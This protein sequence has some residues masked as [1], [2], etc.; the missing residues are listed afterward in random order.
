MSSAFLYLSNLCTSWLVL[1]SAL[2]I[3]GLMGTLK[4]RCKTYGCRNFHHNSS[5]YCDE[6]TKRWKEKHPKKD[7]KRPS[8]GKRGYDWAWTKFAR[9]FLASHPV[10]ALCGAPATCVDHK[11]MTADMM[12]DAYGRFDYDE[13]HYQALCSSCNAR[14]GAREDRLMRA[15]YARD[16]QSLADLRPQ[17]EGLKN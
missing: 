8:A 4:K 11:D 3:L 7:D 1:Y 14:K 16:K 9:K 2:F 6:C 12:L 13:S 17:G 15:E 5:G 10:C